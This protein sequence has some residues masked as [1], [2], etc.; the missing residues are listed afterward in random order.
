MT[1]PLEGVRVLSLAHQYPGPYATM[2]LADLGADVVLLENPAGGDPARSA[3]PG[4]HSA[5]G[6]G[7]RSVALDLKRPEARPA[8]EA[9]LGRADAL[10]DGFR[11]GTLERI[12]LGQAE[13]AQRHP[14]LVYAAIS[15][16]G[17][18]GPYAGRPGHDVTY[19]AE[20]GMLADALSAAD[21]PPPPPLAVG[22]LLAGL[23]ATQAVL[24]GLLR[25]DRAGCGSMMDVSMV[26]GLVSLLAAHIGPVVNGTGPAGFPYEPGYGL[27]RTA[28]EQLIA[29]GVAHEDHFWRALCDATGMVADRD[30]A[31][32]QRFAAHERLR[33]ELTEALRARTAAECER[34]FTAADV[35]FGLVRSLTGTAT[36]PQL[37]AREMLQPVGEHHYVRQPLV[38][39]GARPGPRGEPP[40]LGEHTA[41]VLTEVGL[42]MSVIEA[43]CPSLEVHP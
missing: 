24:L 21:I 13:L 34:V 26:D 23:L 29:L 30:L 2:L 38:V 18:D 14:H 5:L 3:A 4:F 19:Q 15:G 31:S 36:S 10:L 37:V 35:P 41:E 33:G 12:G 11:P 32:P 16:Y 40:E 1:L 27:F 22:D 17:Q 9:L 28:D 20:A 7:K 25:R 8:V 39:D 43:A 6:R 42:P